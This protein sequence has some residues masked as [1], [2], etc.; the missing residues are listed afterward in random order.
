MFL[1]VS[2][3]HLKTWSRTLRNVNMKTVKRL[4][5]S[6]VFETACLSNRRR[7]PNANHQ[8]FL[9][10]EKAKHEWSDLY[11]HSYA[12]INQQQL[13]CHPRWWSKR[14]PIAHNRIK[15]Y[16]SFSAALNQL[17]ARIT[18]KRQQNHLHSVFQ[19][20]DKGRWNC[21]NRHV[22]IPIIQEWFERL[23]TNPQ[24]EMCSRQQTTSL[25]SGLTEFQIVR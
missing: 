11:L 21:T 12:R 17:W 4:V 19:T 7:L 15:N 9:W 23:G 8:H 13:Q 20:R 2:R 14:R 1:A 3:A 5:I 16:S 24:V 10:N 25:Q 6:I 18:K 22:S